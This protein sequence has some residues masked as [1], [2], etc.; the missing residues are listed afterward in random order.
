M[1]SHE[2]SF[3]QKLCNKFKIRNVILKSIKGGSGT[4]FG[5]SGVNE[6]T[7]KVMKNI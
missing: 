6:L 5:Q 2:K 1:K 4:K 3:S 7:R